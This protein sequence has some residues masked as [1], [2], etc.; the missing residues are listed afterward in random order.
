MSYKQHTRCWRSQR[1]QEGGGGRGRREKGSSDVLKINGPYYYLLSEPSGRSRECGTHLDHT[2]IC[3]EAGKRPQPSKSRKPSHLHRGAHFLRGAGAIC[4]LPSRQSDKTEINKEVACA[5]NRERETLV[6]PVTSDLNTHVFSPVSTQR[7][8]SAPHPDPP[9]TFAGNPRRFMEDNAE[10]RR[11]GKLIHPA[12]A[13][14]GSQTLR[15]CD[16]P[17]LRIHNKPRLT[18]SPHATRRNP[19]SPPGRSS[20]ITQLHEMSTFQWLERKTK[21]RTKGVNGSLQNV[22]GQRKTKLT[23]ASSSTRLSVT[24]RFEKKEA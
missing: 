15:P 6:L 8:H 18:F 21:K 14:S 11:W 12:A 7:R 20:K 4:S 22:R 23:D 9:V 5:N 13:L 2:V 17:G 3:R 1:S 16:R 19:I 24:L 10:Q